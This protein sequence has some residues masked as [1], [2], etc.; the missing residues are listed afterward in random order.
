VRCVAD[1]RQALEQLCR[2]LTRPSLVNERVE[3]NA[4]GR[5]ALKLK[6]PGAMAPRP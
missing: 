5:V 1:E 4:V 2:C 3:F 6:A